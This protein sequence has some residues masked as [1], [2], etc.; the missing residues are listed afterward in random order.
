MVQSPHS[1]TGAIDLFLGKQE[2]EIKTQHTRYVHGKK[3]V[4]IHI[5]THTPLVWMQWDATGRDWIFVRKKRHRK[6]RDTT[7]RRKWVG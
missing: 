1:D 5:Q 7:S 4:S 3:L 6:L 2:E